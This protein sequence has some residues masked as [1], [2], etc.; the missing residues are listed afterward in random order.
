MK[1][2]DLFPERLKAA[3]VLRGIT[4]S[5]LALKAEIP[6]S[7]IS[8]FEAGSRKPSFDNLHRLAHALAVTTDF[9]LGRVDDPELSIQADPLYRQ[10][11]NLSDKD[12]QLTQDFIEMLAKRKESN[13]KKK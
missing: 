6:A 13:E 7:S 4:Q 10:M 12:R 8:H 3:K 5:E 9:L 11:Q 2:K 1:Q